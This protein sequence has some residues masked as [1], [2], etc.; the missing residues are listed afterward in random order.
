MYAQAVEADSALLFFWQGRSVSL[1]VVMSKERATVNL[2]V[3]E[4]NLYVPACGGYCEHLAKV[5][6]SINVNGSEGH[7]FDS[8]L[9][10]CISVTLSQFR[11]SHAG[12]CVKNFWSGGL[13]AP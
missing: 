9:E 3:L 12:F 11:L 1:S 10:Q 2:G 8:H 4:N 5:V 13:K 7:E 6:A